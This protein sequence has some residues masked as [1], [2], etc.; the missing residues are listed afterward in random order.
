MSK[1]RSTERVYETGPNGITFLKYPVGAPIPEDEARR[2][3]LVGKAETAAIEQD[4]VEDKAIRPG[5]SMPVRPS[6]A[7]AP[8]ASTK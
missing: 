2:Q 3:G 7:R 1:Y 6:K 5:A 4:E 8:R